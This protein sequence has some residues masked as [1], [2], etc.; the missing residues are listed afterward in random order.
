MQIYYWCPFLTNI[1]TILAVKNSIISL[2]KF[3]KKKL[4]VNVLDTIGEW[5]SLE[6]N[7]EF[8]IKKLHNLNLFKFLPKQGFLQSRF[9]FIIIMIVNFFPLLN[10][11]NKERPKFLIIHLLTFL[12]IILSPILSKKTK[13]ILRISGLPDLTFFRTLIWKIFGKYIF[14]I[15]TPTKL[16]ADLLIK[17]KIFPKNKI[18]ILRDPIIDEEKIKNKKL[19][20][21]NINKGFY[22]AVGRLTKQ[23]NFDFLIK[24]FCKSVKNLKIKK[25]LII[26]DGEEEINLKNIIKNLNAKKNIEIL[27]FKKNIYNYIYKSEG[28]ISTSLY[29]DPGFALI[30]AAYLKKKII[31]SIVKNG[32]LEMYNYNKNMCYYFLNN[33]YK[34]FE[35]AL[36]FSQNDKSFNVKKKNLI[37]YSKNFS[38]KSHFLKLK[39]ILN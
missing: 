23:K 22:V 28:L 31:S 32:P 3:S 12:P 29:E 26:G 19:E 4:N 33:N 36:K 8:K 10:L 5:S 24:S 18:N 11:I 34:S 17:K 20:A 13:I 15:T 30:E 37:I 39:K 16:T 25:L 27:S 7:K 2:N 1:A 38:L 21:V 9:T 14:L 35:K 6:N